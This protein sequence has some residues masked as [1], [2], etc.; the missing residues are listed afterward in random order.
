MNTM[1]IAAIAATNL[2][3]TLPT[4]VVEASRTGTQPMQLA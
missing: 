2:T 4:V 3:A 1:I